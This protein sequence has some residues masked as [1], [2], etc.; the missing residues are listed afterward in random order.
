[1]PVR[2]EAQRRYLNMKFGHDWV[3]EHHFDQRGKL[4]EHAAKAKGGRERDRLVKQFA[5]GRRVRRKRK[6]ARRG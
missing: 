5:R 3:K 4:P 1:M 6:R 2:S